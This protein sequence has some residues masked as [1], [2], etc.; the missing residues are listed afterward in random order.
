MNQIIRVLGFAGSLRKASR[1]RGLLRA[2]AEVLPDGMS[3]QTFDL[4]G[5]PLYNADVEKAGFPDVVTRFKQAVTES[6][7]VLIATPEYN[8]SI[9]GVL[10]NAI[11][12]GSRPPRDSPFREKPVGIVGAAGSVGSTL[13]Q[14]HLRQVLVSEGMFIL[15]KPEVR[16]KRSWEKFDENGNLTDERSRKELVHFLEVFKDWVTYFL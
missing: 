16:I 1:N 15:S 3:L 13:A 9:P 2:A 4:S 12:W 10:K 7:A 8:H 5:I 11:D 6:D 14:A